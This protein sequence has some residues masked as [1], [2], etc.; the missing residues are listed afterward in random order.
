MVE[1]VAKGF[2]LELRWWKL[3]AVKI[4]DGGLILWWW[5]VDKRGRLNQLSRIVDGT[6]CQGGRSM[7]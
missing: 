6:V 1:R 2:M 3:D 4:W 5:R 7:W